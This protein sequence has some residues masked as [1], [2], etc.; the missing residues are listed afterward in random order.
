MDFLNFDISKWR[1]CAYL[2]IL[3]FF[4][5]SQ[6]NAAIDFK[7]RKDY[8]GYWSDISTWS[9]AYP[10][11]D[12][13]INQNDTI[14]IDGFITREGDLTF[15]S[16][17]VTVNDTLLIYGDLIIGN[18]GNLNIESG[19]IIIVYGNYTSNNQVQVVT[20]GYFIV[21]GEFE[22]LGAN[23]KQGSFENN[24]GSV[25][26]FDDIPI[27][28]TGSPE[29][30]D[31]ACSNPDEYPIN[32][33]YGNE[34]NLSNDPIDS[35]FRN[36]GY[37]IVLSGSSTFCKGSNVDLTIKNLFTGGT[38]FQWYR[39]GVAITGANN[40]KYTAN[41]SGNYY[42]TFDKN[43]RTWSLDTVLIT[44]IVD[45][46]A[47]TITAPANI[48]INTDAG[49]CTASGVSLGTPNA[50]DNCTIN[51]IVNDA[52]T[53]F[54]IGTTS[55]TW[56]VTDAAGNQNTA[57]QEITVTDNIDPIISGIPG[58]IDIE[59]LSANCMIPVSWTAP[60]I[61]DNCSI[62]Q[63][64]TSHNSGDI[65]PV[66]NTTVS[67]EAIDASGNST[68]RTF[69]INIAVSST[70]LSLTG[71]SKFCEE[72]APVTLTSNYPS[73]QWSGTGITDVQ[74][75][76]FDPVVAGVG[77]HQINY[78]VNYNGCDVSSNL[79][80][81]VS[82]VPDQPVIFNSP[83]VTVCDGE[84]V[85]FTG[86]DD[87]TYLWS[88]SEM[89][90]DIVVSDEGMYSLTITD[91]NN[92]QATSEGVEVNIEPIIDIITMDIVVPIDSNEFELTNA[93]PAG[94][95]YLGSGVVDNKFDPRRV[96]EGQFNILYVFESSN[97]CIYEKSFIINVNDNGNIAPIVSI[98]MPDIICEADTIELNGSIVGDYDGFL[99]FVEGKGTV[100]IPGS[101]NAYYIVDRLDEY[102]DVK[103]CAWNG[104][105][106]SLVTQKVLVIG[107]FTPSFD[108]EYN[109][110][111][112][113]EVWF[114]SSIDKANSYE[115]D[116]GDGNIGIGYQT[117]NIFPQSGNYNIQL[118]ITKSG[119]ISDTEFEI[120]VDDGWDL[121]IPSGIYT[122]SINV[123]NNRAKI[124]GKGLIGDG[125]QWKI[126]NRWGQVI[127]QTEDLQN[128]MSIGWDGYSGNGALLP[129]GT[130]NYVVKV[131]R[132]DDVIETRSGSITLFR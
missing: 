48:N 65:F 34:N 45:V 17:T 98:D 121:F 32:C 27:I 56:S 19:G 51:K 36:N 92:C 125:F 113:L 7:T 67:F 33:G 72:D 26:I 39:E 24:G 66:G 53:I 52:P 81:T 115:W 30:D 126:F 20:G 116:F 106:T 28:K 109:P 68:I 128:A 80:M 114:T 104:K 63:I 15:S 120:S 132:Y 111:N 90:K 74:G 54:P 40:D 61:S 25:F 107:E 29:Y 5:I 21:A 62:S 14:L 23:Q 89:S 105:D 78:T 99:W 6:V 96:G 18:N 129:V 117:E 75:G 2:L 50:S 108:W 85:V 77:T 37:E 86:P 42:V 127:Y 59:V 12:I 97:G 13:N 58:D 131:K 3:L 91:N 38:N 88:N 94:G 112:P 4:V 123:N 44:V 10:G 11:V 76:I 55:V 84:S 57:I 60:T 31:L 41:Q 9:P 110:D 73:G 1:K 87:F 122:E 35:F 93:S 82:S 69:Q 100:R 49:Q 47:P 124:Y 101:F 71:T 8:T 83:S 70:P 79:T 64:N 118:K 103:L 16:G 46:T 43:T 95:T 102:I 22:M 119:C 130:Y